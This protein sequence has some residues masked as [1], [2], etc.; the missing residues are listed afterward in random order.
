MCVFTSLA[1]LLLGAVD[2]VFQLNADLPLVGHVFDERMLE[3][4]LRVGP[5]VVVFNHT[6]LDERLELL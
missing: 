6:T 4:L 2:M 3:H 5:L 1:S